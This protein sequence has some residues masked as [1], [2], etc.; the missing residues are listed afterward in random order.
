MPSLRKI[1]S[2]SDIEKFTPPS[3]RKKSVVL[4][5][6]VFDVLHLGHIRHLQLAKQ[7]GD[8]LVVSI[9][10][11]EFVNK[12]PGRPRFTAKIRAEMLAA[13]EIVD[14]IFINHAK[15]AIPVLEALKP[16]IFAKGSEYSNPADDVT[17]QISEELEVLEKF[18]GRMVF[19]EDVVYSSSNLIN[20]HF[21]DIYSDELNL[22]LEGFRNSVSFDDLHQQINKA[23]NL[24]TL[25]IGDAIIDEYIYVHSMNKASK[26]N[27][28]VTRRVNNE[29][30]AGGVFASANHMSNICKEVE[31]LTCLGSKRSEEDI[32][33]KALNPN[34][35]LT[36]IYRKGAPTTKKTRYIDK[37]YL[38]K[39]FEVY[40]FEDM[41]LAQELQNEFD[42]M[43]A[44]KAREYDLVVVNDFGHGL[45]AKSTIKALE[46]N[47]RFLAVSA[48]TN[49]ANL[50]FNLANKYHRADFV[51]I[52]APEARLA[53][54]NQHGGMQD[55][56]LQLTD[57]LHCQH[58]IVTHGEH[59]SLTFDRMKQSQDIHQIPAFTKS[60]VDTMGAGDAFLSISSILLAAGTP[61]QQAGFIGNAAGALKVG[62]VGHSKSVEKC[63]LLN[64]LK[65][66]MK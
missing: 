5:H 50:G 66:V 17:G 52:D 22:Y 55:V 32:I 45:I 2:N 65:A 23:S 31:I 28:V 7:E 27:L 6:G 14:H 29:L 57:M 4:C 35:K 12:G 61:L 1:L 24:K 58:I 36:P 19:T 42:E 49:G 44:A 9:T 3:L 20:T 63:Q 25:I 47:S 15:T 21:K 40:D 13:M 41:P 43:V 11:D 38:R 51:C 56:L 26:E 46:K 30:F 33:R 64:F 60:V 48:Q 8:I 10:A 62:I 37:S 34:I 53:T 59:G 39:M 54:G 16:D 18:Q